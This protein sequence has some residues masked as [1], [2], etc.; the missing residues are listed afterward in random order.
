MGRQPMWRR[1]SCLPEVN[2]FKPAGIPMSNLSEVCLLIEEA[3]AIRLKDLEGLDQEECAQR[4]NVSR[5]TFSRILDAARQKTADALLNGK[6]IRI[7]GGNFEMA[8]RQFRCIA[9]HEW[10]VP[11]ETL[12]NNP[13]ETCPE[14]QTPSIMPIW[15]AGFR[16]R[17][18]GR[19]CQRRPNR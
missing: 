5:T 11:F 16:G 2:Y 13:P 10:E 3:E 4:M 15:P 12:I 9:G 19:G 1:V 18:H 6:A 14:C 8:K 7:E 17:H